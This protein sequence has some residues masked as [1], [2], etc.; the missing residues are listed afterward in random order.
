MVV[1]EELAAAEVVVKIKDKDKTNV[2]DNVLDVEIEAD[3][4]NVKDNNKDKTNVKDS[5]KVVA[6][7]EVV[8]LA[9]AA[10]VK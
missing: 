1:V 8:E 10:D 7:A 9:E 3:K 2:K 4:T 6:D 5:N